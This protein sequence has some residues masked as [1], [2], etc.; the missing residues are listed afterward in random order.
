MCTKKIDL[1]VHSNRSDG[2]FTP[3]ELVDYALKKN[4]AAFALTDHDTTSG[5][6]EALQAAKDTPLEVIAGI[7]F[8]T[9]YHGKD[10][11]IVGLDI[12]YTS[13]E[14]SS[15]LQYFRDSRNI[16]NEKMIHRLHDGGINI[17][18]AQMQEAFGDAVWTRAHFA[19]YLLEHGYVKDMPEAFK[20]YIGEHCPY[21]V[22][23]EKVTPVQAV[24]LIYR[25]GGIPILAHPMLYHLDADDMD[26]LL[27]SLKKA[28]LMGIEALYSTHSALDEQLVRRLAKTH[29]LLISGG[30]DF[31]GS[32]KPDIDLGTGRGNLQIPYNVLKNLRDRRKH[33]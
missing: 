1:H 12:D 27:S 14:F 17:S 6:A 21:F 30:S 32:N 29:D 8:S 18:V 31:H 7:E 5:L 10:I 16:R 15:Q 3:S 9:E 28:G 4:L 2:T 22:P 23:R 13:P 20:C 19:R 26:A 33:S 24:N 11:H 25:T